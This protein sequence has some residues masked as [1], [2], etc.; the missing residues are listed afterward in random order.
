M[1][2]MA[3]FLAA[4]ALLAACGD[5]GV[6]GTA[7]SP[8]LRA[9][10]AG[11]SFGASVNRDIATLR[12]VTAPFHDIATAETAGWSTQITGCMAD[13]GGAGGMGFHYGNVA[14]IDGSVQVEHPE[15]LMYEPEQNGRMRLV[16]AEYI[17]PVSAWTSPN[18]PHLFGRDFHVIA[19]F[20][21]W[22][23]HVW[24]WKSNPSGMFT[25]WNPT[26]TCDDAPAMSAMAH[27]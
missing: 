21:V 6:T 11:Q 5:P 7:P 25:D 14:Y 18:P 17:I 27:E 10:E 19:A 12:A 24:A 23:L 8:Q 4:I 20:Q 3:P 9:N 16:G 22:A 13:P 2:R 26:V 1:K 15:I